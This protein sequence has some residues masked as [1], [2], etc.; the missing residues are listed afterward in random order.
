M[1]FKAI[2][3]TYTTLDRLEAVIP[4]LLN[5][6]LNQITTIIDLLNN[7][8]STSLTNSSKQSS[9]NDELTQIEQLNLDAHLTKYQELC[10]S[11]CLCEYLCTLEALGPCIRG[12]FLAKVPDLVRLVKLPLTT[13]RHLA[14]RCL[15]SIARR[16]LVPTFHSILEYTFECLENNEFNLFAR[17]GS[18]ELIH[19][20]CEQL[21]N[22][23]IPFI[24]IFIVPILRRMCDVDWYVRS[25]ASQCFAT[26]V[27]LYPL[28]SAPDEMTTMEAN[29]LSVIASTNENIK[30]MREEQQGFLDQLMDQKKLKSYELPE[31]ILINVK[32]RPYQ[33]SGVDW[34][35]FLKKFNLHGM[36]VIF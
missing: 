7:N 11:L 29:S 32:L 34:L 28:V 27:K 2:I 19:C 18:I 3:S 16:D 36:S 8:N 35:A 10:S 6:P 21:G 4:D 25:V 17:Q 31:E 26:L 23:I 33:Q 1:A 20:L 22:A 14:S 30:R 24:V 15:A 9:S 13:V 5:Q 12:K